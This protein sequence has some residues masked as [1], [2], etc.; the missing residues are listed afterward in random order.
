MKSN[1]SCE[2]KGPIIRINS[3]ELHIKDA[4]YYDEIY[5]GGSKKRDKY[6]KWIMMAGAP[7]SAFSTVEH[8]VHRMRRGALNP[9]F[10]K[11]SVVH[12]EPRIQDR[13]T[14][15]CDRLAE[16]LTSGEV[17]RLDV[18]FMA[19][20]MDVIT[21]Y[22][23]GTSYNY[24]AEPDFKLEWKES[25]ATLFEGAALRR[26]APWLTTFLQKFPDEYIVNLMPQMG[27]L[28]RWQKDIKKQVEEVMNAPKEKKDTIFHSLRD[29]NLAPSERDLHRLADEGEILVAA[30]SETTAKTI[31]ITTF[32]ILN[33]PRV[34]KQLRDELTTVMPKGTSTPTWTVLEQL[35]YFVSQSEQY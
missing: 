3:D 28:I 2:G 25:M 17:V 30:G 23:Y 27:I 15:L 7:R 34:L 8:D 29:N 1:S 10:A 33:S 12:L 5:A 11:R 16:C 14:T 32:H 21:E 22:C 13:V 26:A 18:A 24:I 4:E 20:T 19:L 6:D 35:P 31:S 9:F